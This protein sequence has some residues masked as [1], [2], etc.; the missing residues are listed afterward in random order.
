MIIM[1]PQIWPVQLSLEISSKYLVYAAGGSKVVEWRLI[2]LL[3][4]NLDVSRGNQRVCRVSAA[5]T[6]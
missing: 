2:G 6:H 1:E 3:I 4:H 5:T